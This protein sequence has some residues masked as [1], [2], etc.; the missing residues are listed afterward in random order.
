[1]VS[2]C[3]TLGKEEILIENIEGKLH[4]K[5]NF[6]GN[7]EVKKGDKRGLNGCEWLRIMVGSGLM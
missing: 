4:N 5:A 2:E 3:N 1:L 7:S 6:A